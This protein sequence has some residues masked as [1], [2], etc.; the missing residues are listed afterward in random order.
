MSDLVV[1]RAPPHGR[2]KSFLSYARVEQKIK[3]SGPEA[4][5]PRLSGLSVFRTKVRETLDVAALPGGFQEG[6]PAAKPATN[7][8]GARPSGSQAQRIRKGLPIPSCLIR[9]STSARSR[10]W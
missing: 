9:W 8:P 1:V 4:A 2:P 5:V 10:T 6:A 7:P 3:S